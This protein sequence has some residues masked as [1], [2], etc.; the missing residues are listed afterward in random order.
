MDMPH[1]SRR[2]SITGS[3]RRSL[4]RYPQHKAGITDAMRNTSATSQCG[5]AVLLILVRKY[6]C[7]Q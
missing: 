5:Y 7:R 6:P 2:G 3:R 1:W 4:R